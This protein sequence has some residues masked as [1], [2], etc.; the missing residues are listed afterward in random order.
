MKQFI[1]FGSLII[2]T[3]FFLGCDKVEKPFPP[4][5]TFNT[6]LDTNLYPGNWQTYLDE[7]MPNFT[8]NTNTNRNVMIEDFTGHTCNNCPPAATIAFNIEKAN[9]DRVFVSTVHTGP[10]GK[11]GFQKVDL[12]D[13]PTDWTNTNGTDIGIFFGAIAGSAF[14]GNPRGTVN[15]AL[16]N[17]QNT[18]APSLWNSRTNAILTENKL[19]VN[20]Q[21]D[22]NYFEATRGLFLHAEVDPKLEIA[23]PIALVVSIIEDSIIGD[24]KMPDVSHNHEYVHRDIMRG[25]L[26]GRSF[27]QELT[28]AMKTPAGNY[29]L[30]YSYKLPD[31]YNPVNMHLLL[32]VIDKVTHE[33]Y[34]VIEKKLVE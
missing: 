32:Y 22:L 18:Q 10:T 15:R 33:V 6:T 23:N 5:K 8:E 31:Q 29:R 2:S 16:F 7:E 13:Y 17:G 28:E 11:D 34:Q 26:D 20:I 19:A 24:Q 21:A 4:G 30:D 1:L 9:H 25:C 12:P 3:L 27:G 14:Q